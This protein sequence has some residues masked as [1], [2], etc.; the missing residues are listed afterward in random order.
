MDLMDIARLTGHL[1]SNRALIGIQ[2]EYMDWGMQPSRAVHRALAIA[3]NEAVK[4]VETWNSQKPS[5]PASTAQQFGNKTSI[6]SPDTG[7]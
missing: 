6:E 2:P 7:A 1:P 5:K 4:L 3:V